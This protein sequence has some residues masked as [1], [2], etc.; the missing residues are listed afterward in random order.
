[1]LSPLSSDAH[2]RPFSLVNSNGRANAA[3]GNPEIKLSIRRVTGTR[4]LPLNMRMSARTG[5]WSNVGRGRS[6]NGL[7]WLARAGFIARGLNYGIIGVLA[8]KLASGTRP[9]HA[10]NQQGALESVAHQPLGKALL[11]LVAI[12]LAG[13]SLW[14]L[15]RAFGIVGPEGGS[16][17]SAFDRVAAGGSGLFYGALCVFAVLILAGGSS[18]SGNTHHQAAGVLGWPAGRWLIG[19]AGLVFIVIAAV[20]AWKGVSRDF[21]DDA[22][23]G[24]M[25][26]AVR[27]WIV[28]IGVVGHVARAV[29]FALIGI[30]LVKTA[31]EFDPHA[32]VGVD[33]ALRRVQQAPSGT[34]LLTVVAVGL[35]VFAL[36]SFSDARYRRL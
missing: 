26:P 27:R 8:L 16:D 31:V 18:G 25:S 7:A 24:E 34:A 11:V 23:Q 28:G 36:Y 22:K 5:P 10:A 29:V 2:R 14:R 13:Y 20:Q 21:L 33:G 1:M 3:V 35:I 6:G 30:F 15:V 17:D 4:P 32:A 9:A 19:A 12:G